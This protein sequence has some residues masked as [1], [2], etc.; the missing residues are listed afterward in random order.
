LVRTTTEDIA[1]NPTVSKAAL[2]RVMDKYLPAMKVLYKDSPEKLK[3]LKTLRRAYE[4]GSRNTRSPLGG[5]SDTA[6]NS[7]SR[8]STV[9]MLNRKWSM[10]Q[11]FFKSLGKSKQLAVDELVTRALF[12]PDYADT[13]MTAALR[14]TPEEK[15]R[16]LL[17]SK[18]V[19]TDAYQDQLNRF[20][21]NAT[22]M[23]GAAMGAYQNHERI[24]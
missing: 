21:R 17:N 16:Q 12:D 10:I 3:A 19:R 2:V 18:L 15:M 4:I 24:R 9:N 1:G 14:K 8:V 6:E 23:G 5:G 11:A 22:G 20:A 7:F 13:L